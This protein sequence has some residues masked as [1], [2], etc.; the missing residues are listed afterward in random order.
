LITIE[1][2][3][4]IAYIMAKKERKTRQER[5]EEMDE[6]LLDVD[7][8]ARVLG[9]TRSAVYRLAKEGKILGEKYGKEWRFRRQVLVNSVGAKKN[10]ESEADIVERAIR[11]ARTPK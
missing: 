5:I 9:I 3:D 10:G 8:A 6:A 2:V 11:K 7:G 1:S 4:I